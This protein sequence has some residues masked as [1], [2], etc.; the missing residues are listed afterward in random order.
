M[1]G[2]D[3][4]ILMIHGHNIYKSN[5]GHIQIKIKNLQLF[6]VFFYGLNP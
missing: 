1:F 3:D 2:L 4:E 6:I 5:N